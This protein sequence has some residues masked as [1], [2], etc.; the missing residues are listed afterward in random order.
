MVA[1]LTL[2]GQQRPPDNIEKEETYCV[3]WFHPDGIEFKQLP[4]DP[5][6][7]SD[8]EDLYTGNIPYSPP[9]GIYAGDHRATSGEEAYAPSGEPSYAGCDTEGRNGPTLR[10][11]ESRSPS[12]MVGLST[13]SGVP[14][15]AAQQQPRNW[16]SCA[17]QWNGYTEAIDVLRPFGYASSF[18]RVSLLRF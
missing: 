16:V 5:I 9:T 8:D 7:D 17:Y 12:P 6:D 1:Y 15:A 10:N 4:E 2:S 18:V 14:A 11:H 13:P 3:A